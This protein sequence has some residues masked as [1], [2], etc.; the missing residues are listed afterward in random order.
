MV[1]IQPRDAPTDPL[2]KVCRR[3]CEIKKSRI[4]DKGIVD[5]RMQ[6]LLE[7][8]HAMSAG[9]LQAFGRKGG[10]ARKRKAAKENPPSNLFLDFHVVRPVFN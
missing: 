9:P 6:E 7:F 4:M 3:S 10:E 5:Y 2:T 8:M 1:A